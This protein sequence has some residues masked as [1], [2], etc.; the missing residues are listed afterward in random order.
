VVVTN[1]VGGHDVVLGIVND[2]LLLCK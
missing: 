2:S 1:K